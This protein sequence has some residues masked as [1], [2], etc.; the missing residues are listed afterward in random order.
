MATATL[1]E[2]EIAAGKRLLEHLQGAGFPVSAALWQ[3]DDV[4]RRWTLVLVSPR[5]ATAGPRQTYRELDRLLRDFASPFSDSESIQLRSSES[6]FAKGL[7]E[8]F[9]GVRESWIPAQT[10]AGFELGEGYVHFVR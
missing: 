3:Y 8:Q 9:K 2:I 1:V 10:V 7:R 5:V 4:F 6:W